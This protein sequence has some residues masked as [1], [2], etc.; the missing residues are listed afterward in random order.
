[1]ASPQILTEYNE[2]FSRKKFDLTPEV[3]QHWRDIFDECTTI[4]EPA[5]EID[6]PRDLKD[7]MFLE[8]ALTA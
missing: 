2:V 8:C 3:L 5:I 4:V 7:A 1:M 6:F